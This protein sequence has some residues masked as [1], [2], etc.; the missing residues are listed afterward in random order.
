[1]HRTYS[2]HQKR[3]ADKAVLWLIRFWW[4]GFMAGGVVM[5][6]SV[7]GWR[8]A[9]HCPPILIKMDYSCS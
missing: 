7:K 8:K 2:L 9:V 6:R 3:I 5:D 4:T 1:M